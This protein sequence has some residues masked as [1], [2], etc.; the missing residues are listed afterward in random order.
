MHCCLDW[1][2]FLWLWSCNVWAHLN[3]PYLDWRQL[4][5]TQRKRPTRP[6]FGDLPALQ[7]SWC[8]WFDTFFSKKK[9]SKLATVWHAK[10]VLAYPLSINW[11]SCFRRHKRFLYLSLTAKCYWMNHFEK[12]HGLGISGVF[13]LET[14]HL[15]MW[16]KRRRDYKYITFYTPWSSRWMTI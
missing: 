6:S 5:W 13:P 4:R 11:W 1:L 15:L 9:T 12:G 2:I 14:V 8:S 16:R 7:S 10:V 3:G